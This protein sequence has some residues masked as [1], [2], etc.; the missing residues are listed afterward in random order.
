MFILLEISFVCCHG[1]ID[2]YAKKMSFQNYLWLQ[3][4]YMVYLCLKAFCFCAS[5][6]QSLVKALLFHWLT[7]GLRWFY[8]AKSRCWMMWTWL[9]TYKNVWI[10]TVVQVW[11]FC[12][13]RFLTSLRLLYMSLSIHTSLSPR[14]DGSFHKQKDL[15]LNVG[16][17]SVQW[18]RLY[19]FIIL[20]TFQKLASS[21]T[22]TL[23]QSPHFL[24]LPL[25]MTNGEKK[26]H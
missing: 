1:F 25:T 14:Q 9:G 17:I 20:C 2:R 19:I 11:L 13:Q 12:R 4:D 21:P 22:Y 5:T 16:M 15:I 8:T 10:Y 26:T 24:P 23:S 7:L 18:G 6:R 3:I